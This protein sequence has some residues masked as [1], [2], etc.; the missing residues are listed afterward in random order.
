MM[1]KVQKTNS[2]PILCIAFVEGTRMNKHVCHLL[3]FLQPDLISY[4]MNNNFEEGTGVRTNDTLLECSISLGSEARSLICECNF[5]S[6]FQ[7]EMP[8][9][10]E[11]TV[12]SRSRDKIFDIAPQVFLLEK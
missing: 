1:E 11:T 5:V 7:F 12:V 8:R 3:C 9:K 2:G 4:E 6:S 10:G